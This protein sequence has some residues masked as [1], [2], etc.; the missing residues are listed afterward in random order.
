M[1][2]QGAFKWHVCDHVMRNGQW[3]PR[4]ALS[5]DRRCSRHRNVASHKWCP[6]CQVKHIRQCHDTCGRCGV[7][8]R[9]RLKKAFA[10]HPPTRGS[11][12]RLDPE[13]R[14]DRAFMNDRQIDVDKV[15]DDLRETVAVNCMLDEM[16]IDD[17]RRIQNAFL[18]KLPITIDPHRAP[19][20]VLVLNKAEDGSGYMIV[21]VGGDGTYG[22]DE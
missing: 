16:K 11:F 22:E 13:E 3:C 14:L 8:F 7:A 2:N 21:S 17:V 4:K 20:G 19:R 12:R 15:A 9:A 5:A 10:A 18:L 6:L 1:D